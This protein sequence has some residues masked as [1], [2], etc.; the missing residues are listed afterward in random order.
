LRSLRRLRSASAPGGAA[1]H[2]LWP[3]DKFVIAYSS[4][5]ICLLAVASRHDARALPF[6]AGHAAMVLLVFA[7]ARSASAI[8]LFLRHWYLL[9][10]LPLC[11]K[12]VPCLVAGLGLRVADSTLARWDAMM[13]KTDPVFWLSASPNPLLVELLQIVYTLFLPGVLALAIVL[14]LRRSRQEFRYGALL[15]AATFLISYL[16]Y[17]VLPARGPRLMPY[18]AAYPPLQGLWS[19]AHLQRLLDSL[20]GTQYDC[21][22]SGHV[23]VV[24][25]GCYVARRISPLVF[26]LF[27]AFAAGIAFSTV[28]LRYHYVIDVIAGAVLAIVIIAAAPSIYRKLGDEGPTGAPE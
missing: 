26:Y 3:T 6:I 7:L 5:M 9:V 19:F 13:W 17:L 28:Y 10:Y 20:E 12:E 2:A 4:L 21:F 18:A 15:I 16:G 11:Y 14:W 25:V 22:P 23:A 8:A 1:Q 24:L 27:S